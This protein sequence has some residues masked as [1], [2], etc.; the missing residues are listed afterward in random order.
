MI[1]VLAWASVEGWLSENALAAGLVFVTLCLL[2]ALLV[3]LPRLASWRRGKGRPVLD[4]VQVSEL[5]AGGGAL[6]VD[7]RSPADFQTGRIRGSLSLPYADLAARFQSP[8]PKNRR[9]MILVD[10]TDELS[11]RAY[12]LLA[13][14]GFRG[15][16]V[17]KGGMR[18]WRSGH[19]PLSR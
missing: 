5:V 6:V 4:P 3:A 9:D 15:V 2:V 7:L 17:M 13:S 10:E 11:H 1:A 8:D 18:A 12:D 19:R 14:R 16:F